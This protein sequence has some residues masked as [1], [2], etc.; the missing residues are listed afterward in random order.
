M[1]LCLF[2]RYLFRPLH[3][4]FMDKG[5]LGFFVGGNGSGLLF[6]SF[7]FKSS[8]FNTTNC[9]LIYTNCNKWINR[10]AKERETC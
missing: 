9:G 4:S 6:L 5:G 2:L 8:L 1:C 3:L 7:P 10:C